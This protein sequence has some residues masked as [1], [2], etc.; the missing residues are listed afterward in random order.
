MKCKSCKYLYFIK[1]NGSPSRY[2]CSNEIL[3]Q[4]KHCG[5]VLISRCDRHSNELKIKSSP[6]W[7]PLKEGSK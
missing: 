7:C 4:K 2:Y 1:G 6:N 5:S 3:F